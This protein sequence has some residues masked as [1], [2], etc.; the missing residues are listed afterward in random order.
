MFVNDNGK[1]A[2]EKA[3][4]DALKARVTSD[5]SDADVDEEGEGIPASP[6][7]M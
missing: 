5:D 3:D 4:L 2:A 6:R 1:P 7:L